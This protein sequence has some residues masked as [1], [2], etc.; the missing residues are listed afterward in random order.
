MDAPMKQSL[1]RKLFVDL[2]V[3]TVIGVFLALIGPLG[4]MDDPLALRLMVWLGLAYAGYFIYSPVGW[5]VEKMH[6]TYDL[7][8]AA[9]W[10]A[11][12]LIASVPMAVIVWSL[13]Q[14]NA[15][16]YR[17]PSANQALVHYAYVLVIGGGITL[18]FN[19]IS[20]GSSEPAA[21]PAAPPQASQQSQ[22]QPAAL[23]QP[24]L[25]DRLPPA[26][27]SDVIALEMEDHYVRVHTALGS[28]M[29]LMRLRDAIAEMDGVEGRQVH[30]SWWVARGAV[31]DVLRDG[32]NI[33]LKIARD[34][35]AP[36]SRAQVSELKDA[37][38][39]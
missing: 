6:Q 19:V 24:R 16:V 37:G 36:V 1:V 15:P 13:N 20:I 23:S 32:R 29:V 39:I 22:P 21:E 30:R 38:W 27:G 7:P 25:I 34:I 14:I 10:V 17:F 2:S 8:R 4:S 9:L 31:E 5:V 28:E 35:E 11:G 12:T 26:L 33:R 3:M 18:L